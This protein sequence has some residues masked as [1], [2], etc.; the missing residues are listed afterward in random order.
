MKQ[1]KRVN[2]KPIIGIAGNILTMPDHP[3]GIYWRAYV[4]EDY[5][6]AVINAGGVPYIIPIVD[7]EEVIKTQLEHV[8]GLI[9]S[10][11]DNDVNPAL[12]G[13]E[14]QEKTFE[15]YPKRD[16]FDMCLE[17]MARA[18]KKPSLFVCRGHQLAA[19]SN[20]GSLYQDV[21]YAP[22]IT[23]KHHHHPSPDFPAHLV[24]IDRNSQL[25]DIVQKEKIWV[26]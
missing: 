19:V 15:P 11:C 1:E 10:G 5:V 8:D 9:I 12:Y 18:M 17:R 4:N 24:D 20:G 22:H 14:Q 13:E 21:S 26:K 2:K 16:H 3:F 6:T 23:L 25:F 7:D